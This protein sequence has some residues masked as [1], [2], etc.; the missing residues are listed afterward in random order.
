MDY[1]TQRGKCMRKRLLILAILLVLIAGIVGGML[2]F[3]NA[4]HPVQASGNGDWSMFMGD[5]A[6]TGLN[7]DENL[8]TSAT[9]SNLHYTWMFTTGSSIFASPT[10]VN[11]IIY[12]G[13][14]DGY[15]YAINSATRQMVWKTFLGI[16][17][18][19]KLCYGQSVGVTSSAAVQNG[20][21]YV[22]GGDG[23]LYALNTTDGSVVWKTLLGAPPYYNYASPVVYNNRVYTGLSSYCDP[24]FT[25][26]KLLAFNISDGSQAASA[27]LVPIG[28]TGATVWGSPAIDAAT[29]TVYIATGN[30]GSQSTAKQPLSEALVA[31]DATTLAV[32]DHWQIPQ[33]QQILDSDFGTTPTLFDING[34]HYVGAL[35]KNGIY[36][37]WDRG[38]LAAGPVWE[39]VVAENSNMGVGDDVSPSCFNNG[40][41]YVASAGET[42]N[43]VKYGGSVYAFD[44]SSG[45]I[46][47]VVHMA[48]I[49]VAPITCTN[50][51]VVDN[52]GNVVEVRDASN[53]NILFRHAT[54]KRVEG[55]SVIS[56]GVL[57]TPSTDHS[58]YVFTLKGTSTPTPTPTGAAT[59]T[60]T[61]TQVGGTIF[62]N[63]FDSYSPGPL[64]TGTGTNQWTTLMGT[65]TGFA[66]AVSN[67][68][69]SSAPNSLQFT[70]GSGLKGYAA[71]LKRYG[72][73]YTTHSA[74][75][76]VY[77]DPSLT[78]S[79]QAITL[80]SVQNRSN[81]HDGSI[82]L[83][84][85]VN[86]SLQV[87]WYDSQGVKHT[88]GTGTAGKLA[89]GQ[90]YTIELDQT[91]DPTNGSW[92]LWLN[93]NALA[94]QSGID[95][96][97][98]GVNACIA[99][100][101]LPSVSVMSGMFYEDDVITASQHI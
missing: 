42:L 94:S 60:P 50:G 70:M 78:Y 68:Q 40:V 65:G 45:N 24:P 47:W 33:A 31:L 12:I 44:G 37:V 4:Q 86:R 28:Q 11:G 3:R 30:N 7:A 16:T 46:L 67:T 8:I 81:V 13:S 1:L 92:A 22:G 41:L 99:G 2:G 10:V 100:D 82:S 25:H 53:G 52:Q 56:N 38:N 57:Y 96:G 97:N 19:Q 63:N 51:L 71:A 69:A 55:A 29:N 32:K 93:G 85:A 74:K 62:Q 17:Q 89:T 27:D 61:P 20:V 54:T 77:L 36:Y 84:L 23:Y 26:G 79:T 91:N 88:L 49:T 87:I 48:G 6:R 43:G 64:P 18:Q 58:L 72:S 39:Q 66:T 14:W 101:S 5:I 98:I 95:L 35:N 9:A 34:S 73:T 90:W 80:F 21:L 75:F 59:A 76:S 15:E 83:W